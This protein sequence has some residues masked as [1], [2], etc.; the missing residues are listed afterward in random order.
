MLIT[1]RVVDDISG[2]A[3]PFA[4]VEAWAGNVRLN[5]TAA[6]DSGYFSLDVPGSP[7]ILKFS[8]ASYIARSYNWPDTAGKY[9]FS[10]L[11]NVVEGENVTVTATLNK[12]NSG[13]LWVLGLIAVGLLLNRR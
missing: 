5:A 1:G 2:N 6:D 3:I 4:T 13:V 11:P 10:L 9:I 7:D 12:K 8:S